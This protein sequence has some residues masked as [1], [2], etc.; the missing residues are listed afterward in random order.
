[1]SQSSRRPPFSTVAAR[2]SVNHVTRPKS[3][4]PQGRFFE[5]RGFFLLAIGALALWITLPFLKPVVMGAIFATILYPFMLRLARFRFSMSMKA[6]I[7]TLAFMIAFL[8]PIAI[9]IGVGTHA[10]VEQVNALQAAS[11][12]SGTSAWSLRSLMEYVG[13]EGIVDRIGQYVPLNEAQIRHW[14]NVGMQKAGIFAT[15]LVQKLIAELPA[16]FLSTVVILFTIFFLLID[17]RRALQFIRENSFFNPSTTEKLIATTHSL[18]YSAVV[19]S[20]VT[21]VV[22]TSLL[23]MACLVAGTPN[24][25]LILLITF[26]FSFLPMVGTAPVTLFLTLQSFLTGQPGNGVIFIVSMFVIGISDNIVRPYVLRGGANVHPLVGFVAAFGGLEAMGFY[27]LFIGPV[28]AGLFFHVLPL[29]T[30]SYSRE[31]D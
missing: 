17:G 16:L 6:M 15:G 14:L 22:Q 19:A 4:V 3:R 5:Y 11:E 27:G 21:G 20:I 18:C 25:L 31:R 13:L 10:A 9:L 28:I 30:R 2:R 24:V 12:S 29:V 7:V 26:I 8:I 23:G 1:M